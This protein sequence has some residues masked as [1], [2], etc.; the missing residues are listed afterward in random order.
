MNSLVST[1]GL[2][3]QVDGGHA[4]SEAAIEAALA[5]TKNSANGFS[6]IVGHAD[7]ELSRIRFGHINQD[8]QYPIASA[9]KWLTAATV[10]AVLEQGKISLD[11][12]ISNFLPFATGDAAR[13]TLRHLL[14]QTSGLVSPPGEFLD[15]A[16]DH[17]MT[18]AQSAEEVL[19]RPLNSEPGTIFAYGGP[20]FQVLGAVVEA[21]TGKRWAAVF[22][23]LIAQPLGMTK[24]YWIHLRL[25]TAEELP[26]AETLNPVLQGGV[27]STAPDYAK[28]LSMLAQG[29]VFEGK[30]LL[31]VES[32]DSIFCDHTSQA[33]MTPT[34]ANVLADAH[35]SLGSWCETWGADGVCNRNSSIGLFGVYPWVEK[36]TQRYGLI[37]IYERDNAFRFWPE[38]EIIRDSFVNGAVG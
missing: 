17:R 8:T 16:Q 30:R 15:L 38:M 29:G 14:S 31:S 13:I 4:P 35:Y 20:G 19:S 25:D 6:V 37:F 32:I 18:L 10:M 36:H 33:Y 3:Y 5:I 34:G 9:S 2:G 21:V 23:E 12:P 7:R 26:I 22:D 27:V 1:G 24:S 11:A 28:F